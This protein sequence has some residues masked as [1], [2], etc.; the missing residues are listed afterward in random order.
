MTPA[1]RA[2]FIPFTDPL[3]G[4]E[5]G[6]YPDSLGL[7]TTARGCLIDNGPRRF[8]STDP[9]GNASPAEACTLPFKHRDTGAPATV[10]EISLE[11]WRLKRAWPALQS[12]AAA[13]SSPLWLD[14][15]DVDTLT[16]HSLDGMWTEVL[17]W[18][19]AAES[20]PGPAQLAVLSM[21]WAMGGA[22]EQGYP[23]F[24][25]AALACDWATCAKECAMT[26]GAVPKLRNARNLMLFKRAATGDS[27]LSFT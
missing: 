12:D 2:A 15:A 1:V 8:K 17:K 16:L 27:N 6:M 5:R 11:W 14:V 22:F 3:E 23:H 13:K 19:P 4:F 9:I 26:Q 7:I 24:D 25:A 18:F 10:G 20:W 21:C